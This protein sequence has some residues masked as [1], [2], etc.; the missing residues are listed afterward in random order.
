MNDKKVTFVLTSCGRNQLL[1]RTLE[2]FF[3]YNNYKIEEYFLVE[4]STSSSVYE[5]IKKKWGKKI[6]IIFNNRK[7]GQIKSIIDTYKLVKTPY[8]FHCEDDWIYTRSNFIEESLKILESDD[9]IIQVWLESKKSASR[10]NIFDYGT[11]K[12]IGDI[13]FREVSCKEGWEWGHF[14]FRPTLGNSLLYVGIMLFADLELVS[15][16][17]WP[18][19]LSSSSFEYF[20]FSS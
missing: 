14:S 15:L 16:P 9:K 1:D 8:I 5:K 11:I 4:D 2:T 18:V 3:K 20:K 12:K 6:K 17:D 7:K 13:K 19:F 10:L